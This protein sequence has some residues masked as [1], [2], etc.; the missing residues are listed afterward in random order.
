[1]ECGPT[2]ARVWNWGVQEGQGRGCGGCLLV[3]GTIW[4]FQKW[5]SHLFLLEVFSHLKRLGYVVRRFQP[6]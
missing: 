5:T 4:C 2:H 1:M 3:G 6:R